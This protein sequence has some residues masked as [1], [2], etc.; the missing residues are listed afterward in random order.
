M[1]RRFRYKFYADDE[2]L[3]RLTEQS[4]SL[5]RFGDGEFSILSGIG[6]PAFQPCRA[7]LQGRLRDILAAAHP[8]V[9][10]GIPKYFNDTS[11][12]HAQS[13]LYWDIYITNNLDMIRTLRR[14]ITYANAS[15]TRPYIDL[16]DRSMSTVL[17]EKFKG[18]WQDRRV[19]IVEGKKSRFGVNNDLLGGAAAVH[20]VLCPERDAYAVY[21]AILSTV[22]NIADHYDVILVAL[23]PT[24]TVLCYDLGLRYHRAID[25]GHL[26]IEYEWFLKQAEQKEPIDNK[27]VSEAD[28][29]PYRE[30][31]VVDRSYYESIAAEIEAVEAGRGAADA[32][33]G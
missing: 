31:T 28:G 26:D 15:V 21:P 16:A 32:G 5:A 23:G 2:L 13:K 11:P 14:D 3:S 8:N 20:R 22:L 18:I 7:E 6:A 10:I 12:L 4:L 25:I 17:F 29:N 1:T 27:Y 24:A 30:T 19:L 9:I 33:T